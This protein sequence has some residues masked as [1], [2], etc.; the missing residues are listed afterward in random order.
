[1]DPSSRNVLRKTLRRGIWKRSADVLKVGPAEAVAALL[2]LSFESGMLHEKSRYA[3]TMQ[4]FVS[5]LTLA[6]L[7]KLVLRKPLRC[8]VRRPL[9]HFASYRTVSAL[10]FARTLEHSGKVS[11]CLCRA[12]IAWES[13]TVAHLRALPSCRCETQLQRQQILEVMDS[14]G[15]TGSSHLA[16]QVVRRT[17]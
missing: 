7:R 15:R 16:R 4:M 2:Y 8:S 12:T 10:R 6:L 11:M 1:M 9:R 14:E 13:S 17:L 3:N 5:M